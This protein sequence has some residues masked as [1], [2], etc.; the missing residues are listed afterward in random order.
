MSESDVVKRVTPGKIV[1][2]GVADYTEDWYFWGSVGGEQLYPLLDEL[3]QNDEEH[4]AGN[5]RVRL[6]LEAIDPPKGET[7]E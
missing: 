1:I 6:T 4:W 2:E 5:K 7:N 3:F